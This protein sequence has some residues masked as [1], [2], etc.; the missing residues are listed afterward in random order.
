MKFGLVSVL[1]GGVALITIGYGLGAQFGWPGSAASGTSEV[2]DPAAALT[3]ILEQGDAF[4]RT[5]DL[6]DFLDALEPT[7]ANAEALRSVLAKNR[8]LP[9]DLAWTLVPLRWARFNPEQALNRRLA[10]PKSGRWP[11]VTA[12]VQAWVR[13]Q[14]EAALAAVSG[15]SLPRQYQLAAKQ[16]LIEGWFESDE[17]DPSALLDLIETAEDVRGRGDLIALLLKTMIEARGL[18][19]TEAFVE[20]MPERSYGFRRE[21]RGRYVDALVSQSEISRAI[22]WAESHYEAGDNA[23]LYLA[24]RWG[25]TDGPSAMRWTL[26]LPP[27]KDRESLTE[28]AYRSFLRRDGEAARAW[29]LEQ[30]FGA[31]LEP[32]YTLFLMSTA[33]DD[34]ETTL[35]RLEPIEDEARRGKVLTAVGRA[36]IEKDPVSA[37]A[38]L[39][40]AEL[41]DAV[42]DAIL[43]TSQR[44]SRDLTKQ[45]RR[46]ANE[47][48]HDLHLPEASLE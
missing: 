33:Q 43:E 40:G 21:V 37:K 44:A 23:F 24:A 16:P 41:P 42:R 30:K 25:W 5:R 19:S 45:H 15:L 17:A 36:W 10:A 1:V 32:A 12:V 27:G 48:S 8:D 7:T 26:S 38:W 22:S 18:E 29:I 39:E 4:A 2:A 14:P 28:R 31:A 11:W 35:A 9:D 20:S 3:A 13:K 6:H 47:A 46:R 34:P